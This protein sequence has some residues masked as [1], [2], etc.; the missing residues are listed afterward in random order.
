VNHIDAADACALL[1]SDTVIDMATKVSTASVKNPIHEDTR[2]RQEIATEN[3]CAERWEAK[4]G[5]M[6][7]LYEVT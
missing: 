4:W 5:F 6:K 1:L 2:R 7:N 3:A